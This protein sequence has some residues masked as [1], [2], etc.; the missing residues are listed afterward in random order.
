MTFRAR[1]YLEF[2]H[3]IPI[4]LGGATS[5]DNLQILCRACNQKKSNRI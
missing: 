4:S 1:E 2:D 3:I 5:E